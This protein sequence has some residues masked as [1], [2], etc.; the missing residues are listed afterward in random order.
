M[1]QQN[2]SFF[3]NTI[4]LWFHDLT[5]FLI[6]QNIFLIIGLM[7]FKE[8]EKSPFVFL[9]QPILGKILPI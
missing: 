5:T 3:S 9:L 2:K 6:L 1:E 7:S 8:G 4:L